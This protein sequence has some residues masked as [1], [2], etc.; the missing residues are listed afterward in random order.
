MRT[1]QLARKKGI[2]SKMLTHLISV[3]KERG[4]AKLSLET[5]V[6]DYFAPARK[7]Y[8]KFGFLYCDPFAD[9]KPDPNSKFMTLDLQGL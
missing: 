3:A 6:E 9:Y 5:G 8:E 7:L 4:Y 1:T 2:A